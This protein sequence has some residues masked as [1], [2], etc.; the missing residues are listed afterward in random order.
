M[1][2]VVR[3]TEPGPE[4]LWLFLRIERRLGNRAD[5]RSLATQLRRKF[6]DS[7]EYQ[8]LLKGSYR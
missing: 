1:T 8:Q 4:M 5:E 3:L 6:P 2:E 7:A